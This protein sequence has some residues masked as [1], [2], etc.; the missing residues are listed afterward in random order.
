MRAM[1][2]LLL[3]LALVSGIAS[4]ESKDDYMYGKV[5]LYYEADTK[6]TAALE[7]IP[8]FK[9]SVRN[10]GE[11]VLSSVE[12]TVHFLDRF[13]NSFRQMK[14]YPVKYYKFI[15]GSKGFPLKPNQEIDFYYLCRDCN[16]V[17]FQNYKAELSDIEFSK[18]GLSLDLFYNPFIF[19][20]DK[21][22]S[23][24]E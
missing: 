22:K 2:L 20:Y 19:L 1:V 23:L 11:K 8:V 18:P 6:K 4:A 24:R 14:F 15:I 12:V 21:M 9:G 13:G 7:E 17:W 10:H 3:V 5:S 16:L